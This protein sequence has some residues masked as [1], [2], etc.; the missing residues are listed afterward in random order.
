MTS[1]IIVPCEACGTEGTIYSGTSWDGDYRWA[2]P[3]PY[4][5][6]TGDAEID[7]QMIDLEDA[8][9]LGGRA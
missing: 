7:G 6:G 2:E 4:C 5:D 9:F 8:E 1:P 3:C